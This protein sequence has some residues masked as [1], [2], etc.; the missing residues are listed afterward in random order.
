[1][2]TQKVADTIEMV[3]THSE[4]NGDTCQNGEIFIYGDFP[5]PGHHIQCPVC[6]GKGVVLRPRYYVQR[7]LDDAIADRDELNAEILNL[8]SLLKG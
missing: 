6:Q 1:M 7:L 3:C 5:N 8:S 4:P 2:T